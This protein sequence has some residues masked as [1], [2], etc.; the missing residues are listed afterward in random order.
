MTKQQLEERRRSRSCNDSINKP[1]TNRIRQPTNESTDQKPKKPASPIINQIKPRPRSGERVPMLPMYTGEYLIICCLLITVGYWFQMVTY[2]F[3]LLIFDKIMYIGVKFVPKIH[4]HKFGETSG[5]APL[6]QPSQNQLTLPLEDVLKQRPVCLQKR[7]ISNIKLDLNKKPLLANRS[8]TGKSASFKYNVN[9]TSQ[10]QPKPETSSNNVSLVKGSA[11][12]H[13][14]NQSA[15]TSVSNANS[16]RMRKNSDSKQTSNGFLHTELRALK[17]NEYDQSM[18]EK[19]KIANQMKHDLDVEKLKKQ[20][21]E[22][23]KIRMARTFRSNPIKHYKPVDLKPSEKALTEPKS[24]NMSM[25][26][27]K[28]NSST[29]SK[30]DSFNVRTFSSLVDVPATGTKTNNS[31]LFR[32]NSLLRNSELNKHRNL[33]VSH[34]DIRF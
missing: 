24:P 14:L 32:S 15:N 1:K 29:L 21:E 5:Y 19:E 8:V 25:S 11:S 17:R 9:N 30:N 34:D 10:H 16:S 28:V 27:T 7:N 20:Q 26:T 6:I 2:L 12:D 13:N 22:I 31:N 4:S 3:T 23:Q 18:K 33:T